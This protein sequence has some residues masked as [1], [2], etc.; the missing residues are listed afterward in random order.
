M[1]ARIPDGHLVIVL[2][3]DLS[4]SAPFDETK[5]TEY[6]KQ[7]YSQLGPQDQEKIRFGYGTLVRDMSG[8]YPD[9]DFNM[10]NYMPPES[11]MEALARTLLPSIRKYYADEKNR[12]NSD[13][14]PEE[15]ENRQKKD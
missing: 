6:Q 4:K 15:K 14:P 7:V 13:Q 8:K 1:K 2:N 11:A 12:K 9:C 3:T 10:E 5:L